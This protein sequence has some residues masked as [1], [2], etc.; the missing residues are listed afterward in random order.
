[1]SIRLECVDLDIGVRSLGEAVKNL[2]TDEAY[3]DE[4]NFLTRIVHKNVWGSVRQ[5]YSR[6]QE[7]IIPLF[8]RARDCANTLKYSTN[9]SKIRRVRQLIAAQIINLKRYTRGEPSDL[10]C[11]ADLKAASSF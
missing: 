5:T 4:L 2:R 10:Y 3:L 9:Q 7:E 1:M 11:E 8:E 6:V